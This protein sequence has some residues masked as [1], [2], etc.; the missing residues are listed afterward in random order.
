MAVIRS[1]TGASASAQSGAIS[2]RSTNPSSAPT[3]SR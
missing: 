1:S 3:G 2:P